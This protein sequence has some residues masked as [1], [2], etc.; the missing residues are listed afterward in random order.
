M[1]VTNDSDLIDPVLY[2]KER[3][4]CVVWLR[5]PQN[6]PR[7]LIG[8]FSLLLKDMGR[9]GEFEGKLIVLYEG[10]FDV[11]PLGTTVKS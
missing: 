2:S 11:S 6:R 7:S 10:R 1:L 4:F 8:A 5:V 3:V 9:E